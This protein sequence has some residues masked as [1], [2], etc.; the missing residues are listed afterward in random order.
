MKHIEITKEEHQHYLDE[1]AY[2]DMLRHWMEG[3]VNNG[4]Y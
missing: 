3:E 2:C 4:T 1:I